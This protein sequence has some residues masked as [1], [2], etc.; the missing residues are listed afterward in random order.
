MPKSGELSRGVR[1][2]LGD[3]VPDGT[4]PVTREGDC[5]ITGEIALTP[6]EKGAA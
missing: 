5:W 6:A 1:V 3:V 4:Y 2:Q